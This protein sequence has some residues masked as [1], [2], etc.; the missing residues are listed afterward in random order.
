MAASWYLPFRK[1]CFPL[2][3]YLCF[4]AFGSRKEQPILE[5]RLMARN[6]NSND[7]LA[8]FTQFPLLP[9]KVRLCR[10]RA[11]MHGCVTPHEFAQK[12]TAIEGPR[13]SNQTPE[14]TLS[15]RRHAISLVRFL[16]PSMSL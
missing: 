13:Q 9:L 5:E 3:R 15:L 11:D 7:L 16:R 1:Y 12:I 2:S 8:I 6:R 14:K 10:A 4:R